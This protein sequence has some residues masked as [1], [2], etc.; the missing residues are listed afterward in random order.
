MFL[1]GRRLALQNNTQ[2][3]LINV[4][5]LLSVPLREPE[6]VQVS[7]SNED[8]SVVVVSWR[9][10][11]LVEAR[12]FIQYIVRLNEVSSSKLQQPLT[13]RASMTQNSVTFTSLNPSISYEASVGTISINTDEV[14]PGELNNMHNCVHTQQALMYICTLYL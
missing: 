9:P 7:R 6:D 12:G 5:P 1:T 3:H 4:V 8:S 11:T 10:F 14:G 13:M 2:C